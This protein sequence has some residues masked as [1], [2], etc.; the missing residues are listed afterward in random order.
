MTNKTIIDLVAERT[1]VTK[2]DTKALA[3]AFEIVLK[4]QLASMGT[5]EKLKFMD[6]TFKKVDVAERE[7][8]NPKTGE[9]ITIPATKKVNVKLSADMKRVV[10]E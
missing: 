8:H 6:M 1:G 4:E 2:K 5:D 9:K 3:D 10:K 7:G